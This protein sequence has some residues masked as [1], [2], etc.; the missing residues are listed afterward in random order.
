MLVSS[1]ILEKSGDVAIAC[2]PGHYENHTGVATIHQVVNGSITGDRKDLENACLFPLA[3]VQ[4]EIASGKDG[5]FH[6]EGGDWIALR[7]TFDS[8]SGALIEG[9][10]D[11]FSFHCELFNPG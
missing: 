3:M 6:L 1:E 9:Q 7:G 10:A 8:Q 2:I 4:E 11:Y 5:K